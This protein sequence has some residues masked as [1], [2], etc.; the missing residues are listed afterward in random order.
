MS[1]GDSVGCHYARDLQHATILFHCCSVDAMSNMMHLTHSGCHMV[2]T[3][4]ELHVKND[5]QKT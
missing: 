3:I 2:A 4:Q 1:A 5:L